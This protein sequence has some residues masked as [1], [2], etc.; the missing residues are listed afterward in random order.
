MD[1]DRRF[2]RFFDVDD[3][4]VKVMRNESS[5]E[6]SAINWAGYAWSPLKAIIEG[7]EI[8]EDTYDEAVRA[9]QDRFIYKII[10]D[11]GFDLIISRL[12]GTKFYRNGIELTKLSLDN[13]RPPSA[14]TE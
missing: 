2:V 10:D 8:T 3:I 11:D 7:H 4:P 1:K 6:F 5:N 9:Y 12:F 13:N 14:D